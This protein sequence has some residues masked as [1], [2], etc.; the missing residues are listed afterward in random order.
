MP[1]NKKNTAVSRTRTGAG[2]RP[3]AR[4]D[5][6]R[7]NRNWN[8]ERYNKSVRTQHTDTKVMRS[9]SE[10]GGKNK[11]YFFDNTV[12]AQRE[13]RKKSFEEKRSAWR[14]T[15]RKTR[16]RHRAVR[17]F[18]SFLII[19][20]AVIAM[21][22]LSYRLFFVV[23]AITVTGSESYS[24]E[25]I[26]GAAGLDAKTRLFSFSSREAGDSVRFYCP[27][28]SNT[29]FDRTIPNKVSIAVEEETPIYYTEIYGDKYGISDTLRIM[30]KLS[31]EEC[32]GLI[33]LKLQNVK[34]AVSGEKIQLV[35]DRAQRFLEDLSV[36]LGKT[37]L[38][39][40]LNQIDLRNDF[41]IIMVA[42]NKYKL[43]FGTQDDFEIKIR[44]ASAMLDDDVFKSGSKAIINLED[45][46]KTSVII[47]NQLTFD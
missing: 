39:G 26:I 10:A 37:P 45:T 3:P 18:L 35:S 24:D 32:G 25:E 47:D 30:Y 15:V 42:E 16:R 13:R 12:S 21:S 19:M 22:V 40:R 2:R 7:G 8:T 28:I 17:K 41:N 43:V 23:S 33:K 6:A 46:T 20:T 4:P 14:D 38:K 36:M 1:D 27:K 31:D 5:Y 9:P 44:L 11:D 34:Y 29:D